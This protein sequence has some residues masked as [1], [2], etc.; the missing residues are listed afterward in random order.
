MCL[1]LVALSLSYIKLYYD[2]HR[3]APMVQWLRHLSFTEKTRVQVPLGVYKTQ[4][5][6]SGI[7]YQVIYICQVLLLVYLVGLSILY[8]VIYICKVCLGNERKWLMERLK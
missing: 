3:A 1:L 7:S 6:R 5:Y 8:Q 4:D 2:G